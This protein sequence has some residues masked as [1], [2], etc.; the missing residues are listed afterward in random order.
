MSNEATVDNWVGGPVNCSEV[1]QHCEFDHQCDLACHTLYSENDIEMTKFRCDPFYKRC[2]PVTVT[3]QSYVMA[4]EDLGRI[5]DRIKDM[6]DV[7]ES[8]RWFVNH[9]GGKMF[10]LKRASFYDT[11][12]YSLGDIDSRVGTTVENL[13]KI[14]NDRTIKNLAE[15]IERHLFSIDESVL[16]EE[17]FNT[18]HGWFLEIFG[19]YY[20]DNNNDVG[21]GTFSSFEAFL[22]FIAPERFNID[23]T[24]RARRSAGKEEI[25]LEDPRVLN[26]EVD[27]YGNPRPIGGAAVTP[28]TRRGGRRGVGGG[29]RPIRRINRRRRRRRRRRQRRDV[30]GNLISLVDVD[31]DNIDNLCNE[32]MN[33]GRAEAIYQD[34]QTLELVAV[35]TCIYP[36]Y[37]SGP[38]C[39]Q[40]INAYV[41]DYEEWR[42]TGTPKF[43]VDPIRDFKDAERVCNKNNDQVAKYLEEKR[44]FVCIPKPDMFRTALNYAGSYEPSLIIDSVDDLLRYEPEGFNYNWAYLDAIGRLRGEHT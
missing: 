32:E 9:N 39:H 36:E 14:I 41:V 20:N 6:N 4:I 12:S 3:T 24:I 17:D 27:M 23:N 35:C 2:A 34:E 11:L 7:P 30:S 8:F 13:I 5:H 42:L 33:A 22:S 15:R 21:Q 37:L 28:A 43:L 29:L 10:L 38:T 31:G 44:A 40:E 25:I 19:E 26:N 1:D 16:S 18:A